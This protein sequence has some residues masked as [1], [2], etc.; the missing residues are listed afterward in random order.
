MDVSPNSTAELP[1]PFVD[2]PELRDLVRIDPR[3]GCWNW[4]GITDRDGYG[5]VMRDGYK[6]QAHRWV[7]A[8]VHGLTEL[9]I[10]HV[11]R[12]RR[13]VNA[14]SLDHL[15]AVTQAENNRRIP[16]FGANRTHC[17][18]G[19]PYDEFNTTRTKRGGRR[20]RACHAEAERRRRAD[21]KAAGN[22]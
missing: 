4:T 22:Q 2:D 6:W 1:D 12:N 19:H 13:C 10:D 5:T 14:L 21:R 7:Y 17:P 20:C 3:T 11:C 18:Q 9:H 16:T 8:L 15:E